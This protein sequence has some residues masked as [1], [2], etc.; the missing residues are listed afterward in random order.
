MSENEFDVQRDRTE[1]DRD[2]PVLTG[3]EIELPGE[4]SDA[5]AIVGESSEPIHTGEIEAVAIPSA[6]AV[7]VLMIAA[8]PSDSTNVAAM[9][10][11]GILTSYTLAPW[12]ALP[13]GLA[14][15]LLVVSA[16]WSITGA[17]AAA[18][19]ILVLPTY[20][21]LPVWASLTGNVIV[22]G[23]SIMTRVALASPP[24]AALGMATG[25]A[26]LGVLWARLRA[27]KVSDAPED[28]IP[29]EGPAG[30]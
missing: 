14:L 26:S 16:R 7:G 29:N 17:Q 11:E 18:W 8:A 3:E 5:A 28:S 19:T 25:C 24:L 10:L 9:G 1:D 20:V 4:D 6:I 22:P 21:I 23:S 15:A 27:S 30:N 13:A 2:N 12:F